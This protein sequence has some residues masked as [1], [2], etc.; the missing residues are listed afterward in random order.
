MTIFAGASTRY[1][2]PCQHS[3]AHGS[4]LRE[5]DRHSSRL[6]NLTSA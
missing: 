2:W 6:I 5:G 1:G 4:P 3:L